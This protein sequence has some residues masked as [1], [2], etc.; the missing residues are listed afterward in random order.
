M[1]RFSIVIFS[2][3]VRVCGNV[4]LLYVRVC[5]NVVFVFLPL[6]GHLLVVFFEKVLC[7]YFISVYMGLDTCCY[8]L[9]SLFRVQYL[10]F[11]TI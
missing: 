10:I 4:V 1:F 5:G 3:Y 9:V 7:C 8:H 6:S 11:V 2:L